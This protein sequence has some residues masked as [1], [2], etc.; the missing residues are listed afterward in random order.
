MLRKELILWNQVEYS[1]EALTDSAH[2]ERRGHNSTYRI[3][4]RQTYSQSPG[5]RFL[6]FPIP[7]DRGHVMF[8]PPH[9]LSA[10]N[11]NNK[12]RETN[13][14]QA[15][16]PGVRRAVYHITL[17]RKPVLARWRRPARRE[18]SGHFTTME[19]DAAITAAFYECGYT[20]TAIAEIAGLSVSRISR[21]LASRRT[22]GE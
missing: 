17:E 20:Q 21:I 8:L 15:I 19:R 5:S 6:P 10:M 11:I 12:H 14:I 18:L 16:T 7:V 4:I 13:D 3:G 22:R 1:T 9:V 2:R